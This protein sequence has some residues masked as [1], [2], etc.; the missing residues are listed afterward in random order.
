MAECSSCPREAKWKA[1]VNGEESLLCD[2]HRKMH[3]VNATTYE[4]EERIQ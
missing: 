3:T 1:V 4:H 2:G